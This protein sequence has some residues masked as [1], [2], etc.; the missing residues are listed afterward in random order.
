MGLEC[1]NLLSLGYVI[2]FS[3]INFGRHGRV[4]F[5]SNTEV[6]IGCIFGE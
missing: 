5:R 1:D 3:G 2:N 4:V 6:A